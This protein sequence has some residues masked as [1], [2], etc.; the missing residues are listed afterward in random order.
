MHGGELLLE[1]KPERLR[2]TFVI[3]RFISQCID[4]GFLMETSKAILVLSFELF[5]RVVVVRYIALTSSSN[6]AW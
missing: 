4:L 1:E 3:Y 2:H 5:R 6:F